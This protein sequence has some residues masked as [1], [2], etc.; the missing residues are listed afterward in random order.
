MRY[1][2]VTTYCWTGL[3]DESCRI[4]LIYCQLRVLLQN[5]SSIRAS[6]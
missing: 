6:N 1:E 4:I 2:Q 5:S 3:V